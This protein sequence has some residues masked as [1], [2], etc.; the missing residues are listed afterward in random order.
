MTF[1]LDIDNKENLAPCPSRPPTTQSVCE[2]G[3][4]SSLCIEAKQDLVYLSIAV[5]RF[6]KTLHLQGSPPFQIW[7]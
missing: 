4:S 3:K 2:S 1:P 6:L 7:S 5:Y